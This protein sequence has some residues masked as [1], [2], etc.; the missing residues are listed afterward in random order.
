M[1]V[2]QGADLT[3]VSTDRFFPEGEYLVTV[4]ES[5]LSDDGKSLQIISRID[6]PA[7]FADREYWDFINLIQNDGKQNR[8]GLGTIKSYLEA[9]FGKGSP[10]AEASPPDTDPLN[11]HSL[12][13]VLTVREYKGKDWKEG[14]EMEKGNRVKRIFPA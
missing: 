13:L 2:I 14:D 12:K 1:P 5:K 7:E 9:A 4:K 11:G 6:E 3:S 8:M 10:E